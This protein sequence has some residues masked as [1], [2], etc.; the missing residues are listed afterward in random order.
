MSERRKVLELFELNKEFVDTRVNEGIEKN[1]KGDASIKVTDKNGNAIEGAKIK[2]T[3][4]SHEFR[5]GANLFM[6]DEL[7]SKEKNDKSESDIAEDI[8]CC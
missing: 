3:Q 5:F 1:R 4:R 7:E 2:L 6:L 8:H